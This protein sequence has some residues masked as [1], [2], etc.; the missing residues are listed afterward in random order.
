MPLAAGSRLGPYAIVSA[1]GAG[2]MGEVYL[3]IDTRLEREVAL[4]LLAAPDTTQAAGANLIREARL[5]STLSHPN[6]CTVFEAGEIDGRTFIAMERVDGRSLSAIIRDGPLP[7]DRA[8]RLGSQIA[9]G[10]AHAHQRGVVHRDLKP[11]NILVTSDGRIKILDFGVARRGLPERNGG[12]QS[13]RTAEADAALAGTL[14]YMAPE[15]LRGDTA[16]ARSDVWALGVVLFE[17]ASGRRPFEGRTTYE[18]TSSISGA[19]AAHEYPAAVITTDDLRS[20]S[21]PRKALRSRPPCA[22][23]R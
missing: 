9:D 5:A 3:A 15:V 2:G 18:L 14:P 20:L 4:K 6:V 7:A 12:T 11:A 13:T 16:D 21:N 8:I 1:L 10:L 22:Q 17:M 23:D 19:A